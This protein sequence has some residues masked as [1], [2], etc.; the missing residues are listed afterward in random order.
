MNLTFVQILGGLK[1]KRI[2]WSSP[3]SGGFRENE[4]CGSWSRVDRICPDWKRNS[5]LP[6]LE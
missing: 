3:R 4:V 2:F 1:R 6:H 5:S